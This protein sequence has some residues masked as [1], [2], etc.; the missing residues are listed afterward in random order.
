MKPSFLQQAFFGHFHWC[1]GE[2]KIDFKMDTCKKFRMQ[3]KKQI[4]TK[5]N[6]RNR[7]NNTYHFMNDVHVKCINSI[8]FTLISVFPANNDAIKT[9]GIVLGITA[10]LAAAILVEIY[11]RRQKRKERYA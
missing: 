3:K 8:P 5:T 4:K 6:S 7:N 2:N 1:D 9:L 11:R 10:T